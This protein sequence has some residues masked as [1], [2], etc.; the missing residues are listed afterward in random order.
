MS[1][2]IRRN[3]KLL[4]RS[5]AFTSVLD[6]GCGQGSLLAEIHH[7][8]PHVEVFGSD[9]STS[10]VLMARQQVPDGKFCVFDLERDHLQRQFDLVV[11]SEVLE[12]IVD[13][14]AALRHL[15]AMTGKYVVISTVQGRMRGFEAGEVGHVRNYGYGE[16]VRKVEEAG[17][18]VQRVI[19]WGFPF[20]S[21]LY[22]DYLDL[23]DM[24]GT[25]GKFG[26]TRKIISNLIYMVFLFNSSRIGDEIFILAERKF[27]A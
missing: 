13:D 22:R 25:T 4:I 7:E 18:K 27:D 20:Y 14:E 19:E 6:I 15:A 11:C 3:I 12:H 26:L 21:P 9:F 1:R 16:L 2:H 10:A 23:T 8:F 5:L 24:R 17:L